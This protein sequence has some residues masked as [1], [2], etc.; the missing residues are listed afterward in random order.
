MTNK[1]HAEL[2]SE[3]PVFINIR[4]GFILV[5]KL[6]GKY[7]QLPLLCINCNTENSRLRI[8][9]LFNSIF[10]QIFG[11]NFIRKIDLFLFLHCNVTKAGLFNDLQ[12]FLPVNRR[13]EE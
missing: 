9:E 11:K 5:L 3:S 6:S 13:S 12:I 8:P 2:S 7:R 4:S 1:C 10:G